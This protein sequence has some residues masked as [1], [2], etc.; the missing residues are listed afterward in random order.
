MAVKLS[1]TSKLGC[2][3]WSLQAGDTCPA[4][5]DSAGE[6]VPACA[7]CYAKGGNYRFS[8]VKAPREANKTD[9]QRPEWVFDMVQAL[10]SERYFRW[11]DSGDMYSLSLAEKIYQVMAATP[12][13]YHWLPTRMA[14]FPKFSAILAKMKQL[15]NV[16]V[17]F[18]SDSVLG[19]YEP[20]VHGSVIVPTAAEVPAGAF[21]CQAYV[22]EGK[23]GSCK[24]CWNKD[25]ALIAYP[26]HGRSMAKVIRIAIAA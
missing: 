4:S 21:M 11:F 20:G 13:V 22:N 23:C 16:S 25:T 3:S 7:G 5:F 24:A 8:N 15:P 1:I 19:E 14:K 12:E 26:A 18:S 10:S 2:K 9:W 17:R 6:L